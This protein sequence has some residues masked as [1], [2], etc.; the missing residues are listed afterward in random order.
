MKQLEVVYS[1][2]NPIEPLVEVGGG[3]LSKP[4]H[5]SGAPGS[6]TT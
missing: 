2:F 1:S 3:A 6:L 4:I 5:R